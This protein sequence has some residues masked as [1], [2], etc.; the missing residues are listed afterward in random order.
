MQDKPKLRQYCNKTLFL[1]KMYVPKYQMNTQYNT[2]VDKTCTEH[3]QPSFT[4][5]LPFYYHN[6]SLIHNTVW[7]DDVPSFS[8]TSYN[9]AMHTWFG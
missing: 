4:C 7:H 1:G 8:D 6:K 2:P 5:G 3:F 9:L